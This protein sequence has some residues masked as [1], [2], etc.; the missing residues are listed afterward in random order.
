MRINSD[1]H[2][3]VSRSSAAQMSQSA[4]QKELHVLGLSEHVFQMSECRSALTHM[5]LEGPLLTL[6]QYF[7]AVHTAADDLQFDARLGLE[8]DFIPEKNER[9][10]T[11]LNGYAWDFL[12]GS[13]H[14]ID[15]VIFERYK[16]TTREQGEAL[17]SRYFELLRAA[18]NSRYFDVISHPARMRI[19]NPY[20]PANLDEEYEHL[21]ADATRC[22]V[23]LEINGIDVLTYPQTVRRLARACQQHHTPISVGSDAHEPNGIAQAHQQTT[24]LLNEVGISTVRTWRQRKAEEYTI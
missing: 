18:V 5:P 23:A 13:V 20:E 15:S 21:A 14:E 16:I 10:Q 22:N 3:H 12:I 11:T 17:W 7:A 1:F 8:V 9:I 24:E 2:N 19:C 6:P 4:R